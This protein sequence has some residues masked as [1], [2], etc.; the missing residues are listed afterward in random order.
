MNFGAFVDGIPARNVGGDAKTPYRNWHDLGHNPVS[1]G[2]DHK[3]IVDKWFMTEFAGAGEEDEGD[4]RTARGSLLDNSLVLWGNH[5]ESGDSHITQARPL[6][7][8]RQGGLATWPPASARPRAG[9]PINDA[10]GE[11]CKALGVKPAPHY[12]AGV[13]GLKA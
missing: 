9:K 4:R 10:M 5:M 1:G 8:G 2:V 3:A 6:D 13:P 11:I 7:P 12:G